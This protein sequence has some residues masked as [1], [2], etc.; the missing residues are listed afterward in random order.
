MILKVLQYPDKILRIPGKDVRFPL[1]PKHK[2][3]IK[4]MLETVRDHQGIGLAAPQVGESE[5]IIIVNLE[6]LDVPP[7]ALINPEI[8]KSSRAQT[9]MEE[10]CLSIKGVFGM[11]K[12]PEKIT[13]SGKDMNGKIITA[14]TDGL[15]SKVIQHETDH[16][17]GILIIDKIKKFTQGEDILKKMKAKGKE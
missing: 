11:V 17:N 16:T 14:E 6:H 8:I 9:E 13:F 7:F 5:R 12:R 3:L 15:L 10:G 1:S 2:K 4:D